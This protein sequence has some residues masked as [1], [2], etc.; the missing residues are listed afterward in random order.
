[1]AAT[2]STILV[3]II[4]AISAVVLGVVIIKELGDLYRWLSPG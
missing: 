1:L 2:I 3:I 4:V